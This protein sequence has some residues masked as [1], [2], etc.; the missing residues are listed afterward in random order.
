MHDRFLSSLISREFY[1]SFDNFVY[2]PRHFFQVAERILPSSWKVEREGI[3]LHCQPPIFTMP[4]QGW[5]IHVSATHANA[6]PILSTVAKVMVSYDVP[7]KCALDH[8]I[9]NLLNSKMWVRG[10]AGKF[11]TIY[12]QDEE[13]FKLLLEILQTKLVGHRGPY[14]LSDRRY[15]DSGVLF[16]RYGG[17]A[18]MKSVNE[19]GES[20]SVIRRSQ[21]EDGRG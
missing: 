7:F 9:L 15:K 14:I 19:Q 12:P 10:G 5:K 2:N 6:P 16:Y 18:R 13:Q 20:V 4:D 17:L 3:W 21:R 8:T 11:L 1:D